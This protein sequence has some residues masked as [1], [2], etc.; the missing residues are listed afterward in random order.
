M[1]QKQS[2]LKIDQIKINQTSEFMFRF[3]RGQ[4]LKA[5]SN[6]F[7]VVSQV[8]SHFTRR[9]NGYRIDFARTNTRRFSMKIAGVGAATDSRQLLN[10]RVHSALVVAY[11]IVRH[12]RVGRTL[13]YATPG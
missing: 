11:S 10:S 12:T 5:F 13:E 4:L 3:N 8:H 6:Y 9:V 1:F 7:E 2:I